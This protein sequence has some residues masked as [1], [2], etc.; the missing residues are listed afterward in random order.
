MHR[1]KSFSVLRTA[2][3]MGILMFL[4][5]LAGIL[6]FASFGLIG[7]LV[8]L[9]RHSAVHHAAPKPAMPHEPGPWFFAVMPFIEGI[10]F[11]YLHGAV[12]LV[13]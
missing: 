10:G 7:S 4:F 2:A 5:A 1:I 6:L 3:T 11:F 9:I 8:S 13:L 12:L